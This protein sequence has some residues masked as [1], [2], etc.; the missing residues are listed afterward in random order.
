MK[1]C[2]ILG[3]GSKGQNIPWTLLLI[4]RGQYPQ[5][6]RINAPDRDCCEF[7]WYTAL[8]GER[9]VLKRKSQ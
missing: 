2:D 9:T 1:Q 6:P 8:M 4:F 7:C 5:L 3:G